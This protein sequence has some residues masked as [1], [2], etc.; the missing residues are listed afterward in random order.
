MTDPIARVVADA[1]VLAA[2]LLLGGD[3][4]AALDIVR[5][6][7]W[8]D[9]LASEPLLDEAEVVI[10]AVSEPALADDWRRK[11]E[12]LVTVVDHPAGDHPAFATALHGDARHVL[13]LDPDL[14]TPGAGAA[15]RARVETSVKSP[16]A[17]VTLFDPATVY[18]T[19]V[20][21]EY[22]GPDQEPR[23]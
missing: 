2:D 9:L 1:D 13:S 11:V 23:A 14:Q 7:S 16:A 21:G 22:P 15:I 6:H 8:V 10:A 17:F 20:G 18:P 3:A 4:R 19:A 5:G 12:T